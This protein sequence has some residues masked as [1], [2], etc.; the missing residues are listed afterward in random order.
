MERPRSGI[1]GVAVIESTEVREGGKQGALK[2]VG[3]CGEF[4]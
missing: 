1:G 3:R 2:G 4:R